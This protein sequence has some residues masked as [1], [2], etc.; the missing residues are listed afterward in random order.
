M[1]K[2]I[3]LKH[4]GYRFEGEALLNLW[5]RSQGQGEITMDSWEG[6]SLEKSE[7]VKGVNDA[8]NGCESIESCIVGVFDLYENDYT[9]LKKTIKFS[10]EELKEAKRGI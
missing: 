8:G 10:A 5:D 7:V 2:S 3:T 6:Q 4:I 1:T 9:E